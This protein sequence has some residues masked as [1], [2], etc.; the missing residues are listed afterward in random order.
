[1]KSKIV[2]YIKRHYGKAFLVLIGIGVLIII[3][4]CN[5]FEPVVI[6]GQPEQCNDFY[7]LVKL[8]NGMKGIIS[9]EN[10]SVATVLNMANTVYSKCET[11]RINQKKQKRFD[12]CVKIIYG[13]KL[14]P[15]EENYR[16]YADFAD[17]LKL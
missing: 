5:T 16:K 15:K 2:E 9:K 7:T 14:L 12:D 11:A 6:K 13:D 1:M 3:F 8:S 17:C 10:T 4:G